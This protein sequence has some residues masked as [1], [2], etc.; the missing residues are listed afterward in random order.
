[1][2]L[3][4]FV[5][6]GINAQG[7]CFEIQ[8]GHFGSFMGKAKKLAAL[9]SLKLVYPVVVAKYLE[10]FDAEGRQLCR[11]KSTRL[12]SIWDILGELVYAPELPL[13]P[14]LE[15]ELALVDVA[16]QRIHDGKGSWRRK[17]VSIGDR[18]LLD[19]HDKICLKTPADYLRF[20]P[21]SKNEEFTSETFRKKAGIRVGL[22]RKALYV[23]ARL[24]IVEK[25]GKKGNMLV[26]RLL[27][28][29]RT[30]KWKKLPLKK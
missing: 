9:G 16:E 22:A 6:D 24:G 20:V 27:I 3:A 21:F 28:G 25:T 26:Y 12:G 5:A 7:E 19:L 2:E 15:I 13:V 10:V 1:V 29:S 30:R 11:K 18:R 8:T 4:G 14:G 23:L 17:G